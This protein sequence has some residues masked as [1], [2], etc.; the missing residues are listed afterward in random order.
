V[1]TL[2]LVDVQEQGCVL[3]MNLAGAA[4]AG[5]AACAKALTDAGAAA[6]V[7]RGVERFPDSLAADMGEAGVAALMQLSILDLRSSLE[8]GAASVVVRSLRAPKA[9][10]WLLF[11]CARSRNSYA[12]N[13]HAVATELHSHPS[14]CCP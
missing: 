1:G 11:L 8:A 6:A 2:E 4:L 7:V 13:P 12:T 9:G 10:G 5:D 3:F 14:C